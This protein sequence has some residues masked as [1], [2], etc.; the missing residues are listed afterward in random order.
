MEKIK[1]LGDRVLIE[2]D[3]T[4]TK[5]GLEVIESDEVQAFKHG[6]VVAVGNGRRTDYGQIINPDVN[7]G[8]KVMFNYG[9]EIIV[10]GKKYMLSGSADVVGVLVSE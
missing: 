8:D 3:Q 6:T 10:D 5:S 1:I 4:K 2:V 7:I 9:T